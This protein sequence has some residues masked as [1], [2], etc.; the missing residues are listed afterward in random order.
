MESLIDQR[1]RLQLIEYHLEGFE[2]KSGKSVFFCPL[3]QFSRP[4]GKY[5]QKK[6]G[7]FWCAQWNAWRFNCAKCQPMTS[8]Y[9]FLE[10]VNPELARRYQRERWNS[11]TTGRGHDCPLPAPLWAGLLAVNPLHPRPSIG[12][13]LIV[14]SSSGTI[15]WCHGSEL[16]NGEVTPCVEGF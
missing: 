4:Q 14:Q 7:M 5:V 15:T 9:R 6:G 11:G 2:E 10:K 3:C 16:S 1:Y 12:G 8:M 13:D